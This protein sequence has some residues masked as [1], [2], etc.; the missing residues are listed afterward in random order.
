VWDE[1]VLWIRYQRGERAIE[2][3]VEPLGL[4]L[5]AGNW[6]LAAGSSGEPRTYRLSAIRDLA[7]RERRFRRPE[8]FD[9]AAWWQAATRRFE[10]GVWQGSAVVR[11]SPEGRARLRSLGQA[12]AEAA[13]ET[14]GP[15][16]T[17]G[18][19]RH[20]IPIESI[21]FTARHMLQLGTDIEVLEPP[22]LRARV[23]EVAHNIAAL[24]G[25]AR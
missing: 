2:R 1:R 3:E 21:E 6:Y 7:L 4:V 5:K 9:L 17:H 25:R 10:S 23:H 8:K 12:V 19:T 18:W 24:H 15:P 14:A 22:A 16:D 20:I 11:L 13:E